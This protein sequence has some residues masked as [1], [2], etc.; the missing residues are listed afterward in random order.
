M[1]RNL[2]WLLFML[3][4]FSCKE[5][6]LPTGDSFFS[7]QFIA[8]YVESKSFYDWRWMQ[9]KDRA[10]CGFSFA[11]VHYTNKD[12][13]PYKFYAYSNEYMDTEY[14]RQWSDGVGPNF[15][16]AVP[17]HW[18]DVSLEVMDADQAGLNSE[19]ET[20]VYLGGLSPWEYI[21]GHYT[22]LYPWGPNLEADGYQF[23]FWLGHDVEGGKFSYVWDREF[24]PFRKPIKDVT[25]ADLRLLH[26][27][28][29]LE[30]P[31][32]FT[33]AHRGLKLLVTFTQVVGDPIC[34]TLRSRKKETAF[35]FG[36]RFFFVP[37]PQN[38]R[39]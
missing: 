16:T 17:N 18:A 19:L 26:P 25:A 29:Y 30:F 20:T 38:N 37:L 9:E 21:Y 2:L 1:K 39:P 27:D 15:R 8:D 31:A 7:R 23:P 24:Y 35:L 36:A 5:K 33:Q 4:V 11:G 13:E 22:K 3:L 28:F 10:Y 32:A 12:A 34:A 6:E 14:N